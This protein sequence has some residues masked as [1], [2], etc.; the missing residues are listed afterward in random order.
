MKINID[1]DFDKIPLR[2]LNLSDSISIYVLIDDDGKTLIPLD[3]ITYGQFDQL[4]DKIIQMEKTHKAL[5]PIVLFQTMITGKD[6]SDTAKKIESFWKSLE[7]TIRCDSKYHIV[8]SNFQPICF[9]SKDEKTFRFRSIDLSNVE[10][11]RFPA[12]DE[13]LSRLVTNYPK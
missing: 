8:D 2:V 6:F 13:F 4:K 1:L 3:D 5:S 9:D 10:T 11:N 12:W 7:S